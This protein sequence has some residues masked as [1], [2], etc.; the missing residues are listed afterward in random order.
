[1][2]E[3]NRILPTNDTSSS[4]SSGGG[5]DGVA[6]GQGLGNN[7]RTS[8]GTSDDGRGSSMVSRVRASFRKIDVGRV[9]HARRLVW[10]VLLVWVS[11]WAC[12]W[13]CS[14]VHSHAMAT[15][16]GQPQSV[17]LS[18]GAGSGVCADGGGGGGGGSGGTGRTG[19]DG[20][21]TRMDSNGT[22]T[23]SL[24]PMLSPPGLSSA[25][26]WE[27]T[28]KLVSNGAQQALQQ[29]LCQREVLLWLLGAD[30]AIVAALGSMS[31]LLGNSMFR[32]LMR[33][34]AP[35]E[36]KR[37]PP[38]HSFPPLFTPPH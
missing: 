37:R 6:A 9:Q 1:M 31:M 15:L 12:Y 34:Y 21:D 5:V 17:P 36:T 8:T 2:Q 19:C 27:V 14:N 20:A 18:S 4:N 23:T 11:C 3:I 25:P 7:S 10:R 24:A 33:N 28:T 29:L 26:A 32:L 35:P 38:P 22:R 13:S 30:K 16:V